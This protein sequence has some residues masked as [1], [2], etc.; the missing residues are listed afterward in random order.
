MPR[1]L[2]VED[3]PILLEDV[4]RG[5]AAEGFDVVCAETAQ[6]GLDLCLSTQPD[7]V[8]LDLMLPDFDGLQLLDRMRR[9]G[10][11]KPVLIVSAR[12][13][14][15]H[16]ITGLNMGAD[17]YL[18]KP[19]V[20]S[21]LLARIRAL[22]RRPAAAVEPVLSIDDIVLDQIERK[23]SQ[24]GQPVE[25]TARQFDVLAYLLKHK[26][27]IV[28]REMLARDIW[29]AETATWTNLIEVQVN[30]LR[31]K[32]ESNG[33]KLRLHTIRGEGYLLGDRGP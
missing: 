28:S 8:I 27:Q 25:L 24:A 21:E 33:R 12:D 26:N 19:F 17:D 11:L 18:I 31:N 7:A 32:L 6:Q 10:F 30:R 4:R 29:H 1:L 22:L 13:S 3:Q 14:V 20:F 9:E 16:R 2:I 23:V 5:L 15:D